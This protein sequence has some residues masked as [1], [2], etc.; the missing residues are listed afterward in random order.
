[1]PKEV[2]RPISKRILSDCQSKFLFKNVNPVLIIQFKSGITGTN[3]IKSII[4]EVKIN[5]YIIFQGNAGFMTH[6]TKQ[7][8][9]QIFKKRGYE[10]LGT[11]ELGH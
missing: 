5:V 11:R 1:M 4:Y 7:C 8:R 6:E 9:A 3:L 2:F 10:F